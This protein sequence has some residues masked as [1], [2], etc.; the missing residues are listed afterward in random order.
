MNVL[1]ICYFANDSQKTEEPQQKNK[2][3]RDSGKTWMVLVLIMIGR[4]WDVN[5]YRFIQS[6]EERSI[7]P[8]TNAHLFMPLKGSH[9]KDTEQVSSEFNS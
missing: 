4:G 8:Q 6:A 1:T 2:D 9:S 3:N 7:K 5:H